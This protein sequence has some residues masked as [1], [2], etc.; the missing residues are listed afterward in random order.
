[1][2]PLLDNE[3]L[4]ELFSQRYRETYARVI[5]LNIDEEPLEEIQGRI[6]QGSV[7]LD[8]N[9][10]LRR[11]SNLSFVCNYDTSI[12][13]YYWSV[14]SKY[15]LLIGLKNLI[16]SEYPDIIWFK[17]GTYVITS[18]SYSYSTSGMSIS[19]SGKDKMCLIN[20]DVSGAI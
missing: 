7:N 2:D 8:G 1:V 6:T 5:S 4:K 15:K 20:G 18:F 19:I 11:T 12:T 9:S 10:S 14:N 3:F 13:D 17:L 16:N